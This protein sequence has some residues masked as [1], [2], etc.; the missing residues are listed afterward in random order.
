[1]QT[2]IPLTG[3]FKKLKK[4]MTRS[5]SKEIVSAANDDDAHAKSLARQPQAASKSTPATW[6]PLPP[7][8]FGPTEQPR[9][10]NPRQFPRT[11]GR[12]AS[13][14]PVPKTASPI[15]C[16]PALLSNRSNPD[17][18]YP[19]P[20]IVYK[21]AEIANANYTEDIARN[22]AFSHKVPKRQEER[23]SRP[24]CITGCHLQASSKPAVVPLKAT[25]S[26]GTPRETLASG[27]KANCLHR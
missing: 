26:P 3:K 4:V 9:K 11:E 15:Q 17:R 14:L 10:A 25:Y 27:L 12:V 23:R 8:P 16:T 7:T 21:P 13:P 6:K 2:K 1:M 18:D 19:K 24:D 5:G 22:P 20:N